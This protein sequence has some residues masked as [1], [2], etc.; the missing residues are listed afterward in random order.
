MSKSVLT[1]QQL[2]LL[3]QGAELAQHQ[4]MYV[5]STESQPLP[6]LD[7]QVSA[8]VNSETSVLAIKIGMLLY[9]VGFHLHS[10]YLVASHNK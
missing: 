5:A 1:K 7:V 9:A 8:L 10:F 4:L 3:A 6:L 2:E